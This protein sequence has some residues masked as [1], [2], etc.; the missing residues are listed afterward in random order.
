[1]PPKPV[2]LATR[3]FDKRGDAIAFFRAM[4]NR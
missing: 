3:S 4:L 1:M 2:I